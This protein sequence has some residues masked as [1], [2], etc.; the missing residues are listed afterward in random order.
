MSLTKTFAGGCHCAAV[1]YEI[2]FPATQK[3]GGIGDVIECN[4][5]VCQKRGSMLAFA[6]EASFK[7]TAHG[8]LTD[9][10]FGKKAIHHLFCP[11]CGIMSFGRGEMPDGTKMAA[12]NVRCLDGVD[13][14]AIET[15]MIDGKS[16]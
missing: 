8:P 10:Q 5:S 2:D 9:Y 12:I 7:L 15:A 13:A 4:C 11:T 6:P 16:F 3:N 14:S 1:R